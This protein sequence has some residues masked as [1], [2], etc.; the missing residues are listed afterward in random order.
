MRKAQIFIRSR[1]QECSN[2]ARASMQR[3]AASIVIA[4]KCAP[5]TPPPISNVVGVIAVARRAITFSSGLCF[6]GKCEWARTSRIL[7]LARLQNRR[8][9]LRVERR[10]P[11][12]LRLEEQVPRLRLRHKVL[13]QSLLR[14]LR[15]KVRALL[16][17]PKL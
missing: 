16:L 7:A 13:H 4:S 3:T 11:Q 6:S 14:R 5:I 2:A 15:S 1:N 12:L 10:V 17:Q 8:V 9:L